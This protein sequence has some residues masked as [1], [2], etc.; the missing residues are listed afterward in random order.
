ML[1]RELSDRDICV[2]AGSACHRGKPSHVFAALGLD[3]RTL[4]GVLRLS[5]SPANTASDVDALCTALTEITRTRTAM[6]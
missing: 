2:S 4:T 3:K 6:R 1:V 5:F